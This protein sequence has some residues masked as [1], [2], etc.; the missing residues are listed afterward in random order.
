MG[1]I[2]SVGIVLLC[3]TNVAQKTWHGKKFMKDFV[4]CINCQLK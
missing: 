2:I 3:I 1:L 4:D